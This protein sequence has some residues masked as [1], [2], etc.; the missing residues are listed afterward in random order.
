MAAYQPLRS[1]S[2]PTRLH[3]NSQ[4]I[5]AQL[6]K[7]KT[8][9]STK[10]SL[11]VHPPSS[12]DNIQ[13]ALTSL[14]D[15]YNS[16]KE[17]VQSPLT[18]QTFLQQQ[19]EKVVEQTLD[20]SIGLLDACSTTRDL[21]LMMRE[22]VQQL[23][24]SLRRK[25]SS[26]TSIENNIEAYISFRKKARKE[27]AKSLKV[28][29]TIQSNELELESHLFHEDQQF[30]FVIKVLR[31]LGNVTISIFRYLFVFLSSPVLKTKGKGWS[32]ISKLVPL[33]FDKGQNMMFNEVDSLDT[34]LCSLRRNDS[35]IDVQI[36]KRRLEK[37]DSC[38]CGIEGGLVCL[39]R[40]LIQHRVSLLNLLTT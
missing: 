37:V 31:E 23:Q 32:L 19:S 8:W 36:V 2:L 18:Q 21:L 28:L 10:T 30:L 15:L 5:E 25:G 40:C 26:S 13:L 4:K 33:K 11:T 20:G 35:T 16:I 14:V 24:S 27:I 3:P 12:S 39:F 6:T 1:I 7:L 38:I 34:M 29:K 17:L 9:E 22:K